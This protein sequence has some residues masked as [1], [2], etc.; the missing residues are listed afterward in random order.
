MPT[1]LNMETMAAIE[2]YLERGGRAIGHD[3]VNLDCMEGGGEARGWAAEMDE[4]RAVYG[5]GEPY[6]GRP[7]ITYRHYVV[8]PDPADKVDLERLREL[9]LS[10]AER[11]FGEYQVT[12]VYHDDNEHAIPHAHVVVGNTNVETGRRLHVPDPKGLNRDLQ[13]MAR[14][15]GLG[16]L[17]DEHAVFDRRAKGG[18]ARTTQREYKGRAERRIERKGGYSWVADIRQRARTARALAHDE[19]SYRSVLGALGVELSLNSPN[20]R[21]RDFLYALSDHPARR[22][23]GEKLGRC[24]GKQALEWEWGYPT[25]LK[26]DAID[27]RIEG[28]VLVRDLDELGELARLMEALRDPRI[29]SIADIDWQI[30]LLERDLEAAEDAQGKATIAD[31]LGRFGDA[32]KFAVGHG[33]LPARRPRPVS[34]HEPRHDSGSWHDHH[35]GS[36]GDSPLAP[37]LGQPRQ[38]RLVPLKQKRGHRL[39]VPMPHHAVPEPERW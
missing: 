16:Y 13:R 3:F 14:E 38:G 33:M 6:R 27:K 12:I 26:C 24:Y 31:K 30:G 4:L 29:A 1:P 23:G 22:V 28:A 18:E 36:H 7:A 34:N 39:R 8:S 35:S 37:T 17:A 9:A 15:R 5:N 2:R 10:W 21:R 11:H 20:A 25:A 19:A 32:H